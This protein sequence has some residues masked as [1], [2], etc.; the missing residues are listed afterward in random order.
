VTQATS[1]VGAPTAADTYQ[2]VVQFFARQMRLL[3]EG[4]TDEWAD[5][6]TEDGT[7]VDEDGAQPVIGRA[8]I[9]RSARAHHE[10]AG[11]VQRR[12]WLGMVETAARPDGT[13]DAHCYAL[14]L[15][16]ARG[17]RP[18]IQSSVECRDVLVADGDNLR[19]RL[20]RVRSDSV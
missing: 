18:Q 19:V 10:R 16:T 17:E 3:D 8:A 20:R 11:D 1:D 5:T 14:V 13:I 4:R 15:A 9:A 2:R 7:F 6:F 12:H